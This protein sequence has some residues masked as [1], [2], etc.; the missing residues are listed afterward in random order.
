[1]QIGALL[2]VGTLSASRSLSVNGSSIAAG[3]GLVVATG[4]NLVGAKN[5]GRAK[6]DARAEIALVM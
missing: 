5:Q 6:R 3:Q 4:Q 1:M 2:C